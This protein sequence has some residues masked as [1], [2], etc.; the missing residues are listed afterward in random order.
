MYYSRSERCETPSFQGRAWPGNRKVINL[1]VDAVECALNDVKRLQGSCVSERGEIWKPGTQST[2]PRIKPPPF[3][4]W[5]RCS[6]MG[7]A[8]NPSWQLS[9][10]AANAA[11]GGADRRS[12]AQPG[13]RLRCKLAIAGATLTGI[14]PLAQGGSRT[15]CL[16]KKTMVEQRRTRTGT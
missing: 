7:P 4:A 16:F 12:P 15:S 6:I 13:R 11:S 5:Q 1:A 3:P 8:T 2:T 9:G 10:G 14:H